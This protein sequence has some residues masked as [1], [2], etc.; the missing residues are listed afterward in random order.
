MGLFFVRSV[1]G[2]I[3]AMP[4][5]PKPPTDYLAN[6]HGPQFEKHCSRRNCYFFESAAEAEARLSNAQEL[7]PYLK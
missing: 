2:T 1:S 7:S 6:R 5:L 4:F 3:F